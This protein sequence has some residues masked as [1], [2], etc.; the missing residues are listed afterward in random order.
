MAE[1]DDGI[2]NK[3]QAALIEA[4][5]WL[6]DR[7][8]G[9]QDAATAKVPRSNAEIDRRIT[10]YCTMAGTAGFV[11][12]VGGALTLPVT[13]PAN[14]LSV[15]ALQLRLIAEVA[16]ARGY[17]LHGPEARTLALACLTGNAALDI[18]K[19]AGVRLGVSVGQ[20]A[21][22]QIAGATIAKINQAVGFQLLARAGT[23]GV[24]NLTKFVPVV[25][26]LVGGTVDALST[27]AVGEIAKRVFEALPTQEPERVPDGRGDPDQS[28]LLASTQK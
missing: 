14:L 4:L 19:E 15:A 23:Q 11:T 26:G 20:R 6:Y 13:L 3:A 22:G 24:V 8:V 27:K 16:S 21:I 17:H 28:N 25:G 18:L 7:V 9:S 10:Y 2:K 1:A 5:N 12:N